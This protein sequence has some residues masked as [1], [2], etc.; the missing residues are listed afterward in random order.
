MILY[1]VPHNIEAFK[2]V[3][4]VLQ[5]EQ[6]H[7]LDFDRLFCL[8]IL[9]MAKPN[10]QVVF[11]ANFDNVCVVL[12]RFLHELTLELHVYIRCNYNGQNGLLFDAF[13]DFDITIDNATCLFLRSYQLLY[14]FNRLIHCLL[15]NFLLKPSSGI[16]TIRRSTV[17]PVE[18][19]AGF[20]ETESRC[21][22]KLVR[23]F[24]CTG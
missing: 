10:T 14:R 5:G 21:V 23:T 19:D 16:R 18:A 13:G 7:W 15:I 6:R 9:A 11:R 3:S 17:Q 4:V 22:T 24:T 20:V 8:V 12:F 2:L 1:K